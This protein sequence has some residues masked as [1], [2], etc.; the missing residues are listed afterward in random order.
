MRFLP[1]SDRELFVR[2]ATEALRA[3]TE[4]GSYAGVDLV[5]E[6]WRH[7]AEIWADPELA[8]V[9]TSPVDAPAGDPVRRP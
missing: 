7:T 1:E 2:D 6:Q 9:L 4:L 3:A 8:E 5:V